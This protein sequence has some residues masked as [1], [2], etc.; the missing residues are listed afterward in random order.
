MIG[1]YCQFV[2]ATVVGIGVLYAWFTVG[3][4]RSPS[5]R[6]PLWVIRAR[7]VANP[8]VTRGV[9]QS[10][11][12]SQGDQTC[13][14]Y[15]IKCVMWIVWRVIGNPYKSR[16]TNRIEY[17]VLFWKDRSRWDTRMLVYP[18]LLVH[19]KWLWACSGRTHTAE[20]RVQNVGVRPHHHRGIPALAGH[21]D[22]TVHGSTGK[23][24]NVA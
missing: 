20:V 11:W 8:A 3:G 4:P 13:C 7:S 19:L 12:G 2:W 14:S 5:N 17:L 18:P 15:E 16:S 22:Q 23:T 21:S 1:R 24:S 9:R 10:L 6:A